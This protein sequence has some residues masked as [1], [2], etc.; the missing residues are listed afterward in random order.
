[1]QPPGFSLLIWP[2][3]IA[4]VLNIG[5]WGSLPGE[6]A[7]G[8]LGKVPIGLHAILYPMHH[9]SVRLSLVL[10]VI[11]VPFLH[12][13][14]PY[15]PSP[16]PSDYSVTVSSPPSASACPALIPRM[17]REG[18]SRHHLDMRSPSFCSA[19]RHNSMIVRVAMYCATVL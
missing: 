10:L 5:G 6:E 15:S 1:M 7:S 12:P 13:S 19:A 11:S 14:L 2:A 9:T 8:S 4:S 16:S 3:C 18:C 17:S